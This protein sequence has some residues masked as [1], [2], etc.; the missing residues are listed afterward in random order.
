K[1]DAAVNLHEL[2]RDAD[3][4][5]F[6]LFSSVVGI[7]GGPGQANYAAANTFLD[8]LAQRRRAEGLAATSLAWGLWADAS[9]MTGHMDQTA[10]LRMA[11]GGVV[12]L[13]AELGRDLFDLGTHAAEPLLVTARLDLTALRAQA[14]DGTLHPMLRGLVRAPRRTAAAARTDA[15]GTSLARRLAG[16]TPGDQEHE[17][18]GV[19]R[20]CVALVLGYASDRTVDTDRTFKELGFD[21]LLAV[22]LRNR[23]GEASGLR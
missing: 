15:A 3:L 8:A 16:L 5:A 19:I 14:G 7:L 12:G 1:V 9:G 21:S 17:V 20:D 18:L 2:T 22:E 4:T 11:R 10:L 6:V 13:P 23:L